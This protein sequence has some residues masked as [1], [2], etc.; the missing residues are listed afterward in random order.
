MT[1]LLHLDNGAL[2]L[3]ALPRGAALRDIRLAGTAHS[4]ILGHDDP[5]RYD[6]NP[7]YMGVIVGRVANRIARGLAVIDGHRYQL[8]RNEGGIQTLHGGRDGSSARLWQVARHEA[9]LLEFSD[10][11]PDGHMGFP[12]TLDVS[13]IYRLDGATLEVEVTARSDAPT[14]CSFAPHLYFNLSGAADISDHRLQVPADTYLPVDNGI[15][16]GGPAPVAG[17]PWDMRRPVAPPPGI[18]HNLCLAEAPRALT[19]IATLEAGGITMEITSTEPGLQIYDGAALSG[20]AG[21]DGRVYG[22]RAGVALEPQRWPDAVNN[23]WRAQT[24]L[25]PG[26]T[27]HALSRFSFRC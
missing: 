16:T 15:P 23:T 26:D 8:D 2:R 17:T 1:G 3:T 4:L 24:D 5:S 13:V 25:A 27:F 7:R 22:A 6:E 20:I 21:L 9:D 10:T 12:G 19:R 14:I 11:L 18:D